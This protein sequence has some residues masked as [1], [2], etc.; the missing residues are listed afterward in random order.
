M[1]LS[2]ENAVFYTSKQEENSFQL[3]FGH[4]CHCKKL[5][6]MSAGGKTAPTCTFGNTAYLHARKRH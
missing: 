6:M 2:I 1:L 5:Y 3:V 4:V